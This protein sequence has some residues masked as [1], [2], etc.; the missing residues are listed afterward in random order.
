MD[1]VMLD[2]TMVIGLMA[3]LLAGLTYLAMRWFYG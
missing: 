3:F 1:D 2:P